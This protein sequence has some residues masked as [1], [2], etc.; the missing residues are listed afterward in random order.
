MDEGAM[1]A[2]QTDLK[3]IITYCNPDFIKASGFEED[4]L[5]GEPHN[6]VRHPDMPPEAFADMWRT[7]QAGKPWSGV[8]KNRRKNGGFYWVAANATPIAEDGKIT[9]YMSVRRKPSIE[10]IR[11]A[12]AVYR[13]MR[14]GRCPLRISEGALVRKGAFAAAS[15]KLK[16]LGV[17]GR[18]VLAGV[19]FLL[20]LASLAAYMLA[21]LNG[22]DARA[23]RAF[24]RLAAEAKADVTASAGSSG[25]RIQ[26]QLA[27]Y[28]DEVQAGNREL[29]QAV[30]GM[31][32]FTLL[33]GLALG[34]WMMRTIMGRLGNA[35]DVLERMSRGDYNNAITS[36]PANELGHMMNAM[37]AM[38]TRLG[39]D[40]VEMARIANENLGVRIS[41]DNVSTGV[42]IA[43]PAGEV[44]YVNK[45][46]QRMLRSIE[47]D[48]R[49]NC[50]KF[51]SANVL[52]TRMEVFHDVG[53]QQ[54]D[55]M[56]KLASSYLTRLKLG[57]HHF[58]IVFNP[59]INKRGEHLGVVV[60]WDDQTTEVAVQQEVAEIVEA[61]V[62]GDFSKRLEVADKEGFMRGLSEGI[63]RVVETSDN[64]LREVGRMLSSLAQGDLTD[65]ITSDYR[66]AFA[67]L[68]D[69]ANATAEKLGEIIGRIKE[70]TEAINTAAQEIS[71]GNNDLSH[72]TEENAASLEET[73]SSMEELTA[74]VR[75]N[76]EN[77][78]QAN[79]LAIGAS[80]VALKGGDVVRDVVKTMEAIN[81]SS[82]KI[83]DIIGVID[84]ISFQTNILALNAAVEAARAGEQGRGFAVVA[85]EVRSLSQR[86]A[87]AA[88]DIKALI[89]H[90]VEQVEGGSKLVARAGQTMAEVV[91]SIQRVTDIMSEIT[92]ASVEQTAGIEQVNRAVTQMDEVTQHNAAMVEEAAAA[93]ESLEEQAQ[94]LA[95]AVAAFKVDESRGGMARRLAPANAAAHASDKSVHRKGGNRQAPRLMVQKRIGSGRS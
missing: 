5:I 58:S 84:S 37:R 6:L 66:G 82:R 34:Y 30:L 68:K 15:G 59:V 11:A 7:L 28:R 16:G 77:S 51:D 2:S 71:A 85:G 87:M 75:H 43:N 64:G 65:R 23:T 92:S 24:D 78:R 40:V 61:A 76:A 18:L 8:V 45:A 63:N 41:L 79:Q 10:Q 13:E 53:A 95:D 69:D 47:N 48:I 86:S 93:A 49:K 44:T 89:G 9:G 31:T 14:E 26:A 54:Q 80:D 29:R 81:E 60:E 12:E 21:G 42:M 62:Q 33:A 50:P 74:T 70:A 1:L 55:A 36:Q 52:G 25:A 91:T 57:E 88:K 83:V 3:G 19:F 90:S 73:A 22:N 56:G 72:R 27:A 35:R 20:L 67:Q 32:V 17:K 94:S 4:E 39:F 46:M 38:Q